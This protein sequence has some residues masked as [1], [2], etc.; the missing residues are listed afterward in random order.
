MS[1]RK[2][3]I[4]ALLKSHEVADIDVLEKPEVSEH[5]LIFVLHRNA[6]G[7]DDGFFR[8]LANELGL[9]YVSGDE[10]K[11]K[12]SLA[13]TLP[14]RSLE[15]NLVVPL[16]V[17]SEKVRIATANP[18]NTDF[19]AV[20]EDLFH[21]KVE[22]S[23]SSIRDI[24]SAIGREYEELHKYRA[25]KDLR[26]RN[27]DESAYVVLYPW[28]RYFI[29][30][31]ALLVAVLF[32]LDY[33]LSFVVVFAAINLTY[34]C[35]NPVKFYVSFRGFQGSRR[36]VR[37]SE[38]DLQRVNEMDLPTYTILIP[39]Y[40]E[41][42]VLPHIVENI[43]RL[44]YPRDKLDIKIL[45][46][47]KDEETISEAK[48]L[49]L[50]GEPQT[51]IAPILSSRQA[52][53][54]RLKF[55]P[56]ARVVDSGAL[57]VGVLESVSGQDGSG[58]ILTVKKPTGE[59]IQIP[60]SFVKSSGDVVVLRDALDVLMVHYMRSLAIFDAVVVP[61]AEIRTKPRACNYGLFRAKGEYCVIY[62]AEDDPEPD[63][64]KKAAVA[65]SR[66]PESLV[67]LQS[68]LNFYNPKENLLTRWFSLEYSFWY[69]YY[70][71]GLDRVGAPLPLG[72]TS[73][74]FRVKQLRELGGWDPYN[75]TED[76]D[77]GVRISR[78]K[79]KTAMLNSYTFEEATKK[80]PSW[81]RQRS[82]WAKGYAQTY[83]VHMRHPIRLVREMGWKQFFYFQ[84]TFGGNIFLPLV[85]PILWVVTLLTILRPGMFDF[86]FFYP[87]VYVCIF[88][89]VVGNGVYMIL[90]MGP[91]VLKKHYTSI[92]LALLIPLYW[93]LISIGDWR[94]TIQLVTKPF[95]WEKTQH[96][97]THLYSKGMQ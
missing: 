70:L 20:L 79:L 72:G 95:Y 86:L 71:D 96:G 57:V 28:Q 44:D 75:V 37:V 50:F 73:N 61:D 4:I 19:F 40:R 15:E 88:N 35:V 29:I 33:P 43:Y 38:E 26:Y 16:E 27:P 82:R 55:A 6:Y 60:A 48:R 47:E 97:L 23:V 68:R 85:N 22:I 53:N 21:A 31:I 42:K 65:F 59:M 80:L 18:F 25:L 32:V 41:A 9:A 2:A 10:L 81:I 8:D 14:Y 39:I 58:P 11:G 17:S 45:M 56:S 1:E 51:I 67:C 94:G 84:L 49:G 7:I 74:H 13:V 34:F 93:V 5:D 46:E 62:D 3:R 91:Y 66:S 24:E 87:I 54:D 92:P 90:H 77:L 36:S 30:G 63:Q 76:A 52:E 69:D 78:K 83:L 12:A 89:L 64:L